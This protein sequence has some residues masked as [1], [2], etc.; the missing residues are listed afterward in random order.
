MSEPTKRYR[1]YFTTTTSVDSYVDVD[2]ESIEHA[3]Q[4]ANEAT[5][6]DDDALIQLPE[7]YNYDCGPNGEREILE[8][9]EAE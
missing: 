5:E 2:A 9:E 8:E 7:T 1:V 3:M 6:K 4:K